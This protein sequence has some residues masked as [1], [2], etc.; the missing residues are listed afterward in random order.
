M[1]RIDMFNF[2]GA[3]T[4]NTV[5]STANEAIVS[6]EKNPL[7]RELLWSFLLCLLLVVAELWG[8]EGYGGRVLQG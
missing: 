5:T 2:T 3:N 8:L 4:V 7:L 6:L 1:M